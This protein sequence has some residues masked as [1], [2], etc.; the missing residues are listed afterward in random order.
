MSYRSYC[1]LV[2]TVIYTFN[3]VDREI[4]SIILEPLKNELSLSDTQ[5]G[6]VTG[7]AFAFF[8]AT[9]GIPIAM[10]ADRF[11]RRNILAAAM[12]IW[13]I[14]TALCGLAGSFLQLVTARF[15]VAVG[16]AAGAPASISM[17]SDLFS[18]KQ[19]S[20]A[21]AV[22]AIGISAGVI[23]AYPLG[24]W[25]A[26]NVGWR[27]AFFVAASPSV[28]LILLLLLTV[29]E[30]RR[31]SETASSDEGAPKIGEVI[32]FMWSQKSLRHVYI[33]YSL[34]SL[35]AYGV[36]V[37][38]P[39]FVVRSHGESLTQIGFMF[40]FIFG[41]LGIIFTYF[42][43]VVTDRLASHDLRWNVWVITV[44]LL[45]TLPGC[46][47]TFTSDSS[48]NMYW[49]SAF[50]SL[51]IIFYF[52]PL[53]SLAASLVQNRMRAV[54]TA[55]LL[56]V[57]NMLGG[58]IGPQLI[59]FGSDMLSVSYGSD[60]LRIMLA[61]SSIFALWAALHFFLASRTLVADYER[62]NVKNIRP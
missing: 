58:G 32:K 2:L 38:F 45:V 53:F 17:I 20:T 41:F 28:F 37:W 35:Y 49:W 27:Y 52:G 48:I 24:G 22:F 26:D 43:G 18:M 3:Q 47:L 42:G 46:I 50:I 1:L 21:M 29:K 61:A 60:S 44:G 55:L 33:G 39:S 59:G 51:A 56:F 11:S 6:F 31:S 36:V 23:I 15:G 8:Y 57:S 40:A 7:M 16:E 62:V 4:I 14:M 19:R 25:L 5:L 30:P 9:M 10:L 13:S 54:A 34:L 12:F